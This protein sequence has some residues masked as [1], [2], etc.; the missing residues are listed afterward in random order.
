MWTKRWIITAALAA[1]LLIAQGGP[2]ALAQSTGATPGSIP[3]TADG[4]STANIDLVTQ[5]Y[6]RLLAVAASFPDAAGPVV[7][8]E[9]NSR[10]VAR[11]KPSASAVG[12]QQ[13]IRAAAVP[14]DTLP[15]VFAPA[16]RSIAEL[17]AMGRYQEWAGPYAPFITQVIVNQLTE[18]VEIMTTAHS[19][20]IAQ[21]GA[22]RFGFSPAVVTS[23]VEKTISRRED[24]EPYS[25]GIAL[26]RSE[27][28]NPII[29]SAYC[30]GGFRFRKNSSRFFSTAGHCGG[31]N[32][33]FW[34]DDANSIARV[35]GNYEYTGVDAS[36]LAAMNGASFGTW[37]WFGGP[38]TTNLDPV[39][40]RQTA[41]LAVGAGVYFDGANGGRVYGR[42]IGFDDCLGDDAVWVDTFTGHPYD[43]EVRPGDSGGPV[44][45][46]NTSTSRTDDHVAVGLVQCRGTS[47]GTLY[48]RAAYTP[49]HR[50]EQVSDSTVD[51]SSV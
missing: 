34:H 47:G 2:S 37:I 16:A 43:G 14:A 7:F 40:G 6:D 22:A 1:L 9:V 10:L 51:L 46:W 18:T 32:T 42:V 8:D 27:T 30:T 20:A 11:V 31:Y 38:N 50:I 5:Q 44:V 19:T 24:N 45:R 41:N 48:D 28:P 25:P 35:S 15:V 21:L 23:S 17:R 36:L 33:Q 39:T 29:Y 26:W 49:V 13:A 3:M 12:L 4:F